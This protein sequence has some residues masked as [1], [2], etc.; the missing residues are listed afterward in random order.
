MKL[1]TAKRWL[2]LFYEKIQ[3]N[4]KVLAELDS[5][6][7]GDGDHGEN[8]LRGMTAVVNEVEPREFESTADLFKNAGML[9]LTKVGGVSGTLYGS[10]FFGIAH[11]EKEDGT[12][13]QDIKEGLEMIQRRG[14]AK[15]GDKTMV[16][17]WAPVV[18]DLKENQLTPERIDEYV[19][20][21]ALLRAA[22][23]RQAL[24]SDGSSGLVDP[25]SYSS[26]LLFKALIEAEEVEHV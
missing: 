8:M 3:E 10:A 6:M 2:I 12:L 23:G 14:Q 26:G 5:F 4:E 21:T 18:D 1:E 17:V 9:L 11:A 13:Y 16:D 24:L 15:V 19:L 22:K 7:G 20:A 25:G